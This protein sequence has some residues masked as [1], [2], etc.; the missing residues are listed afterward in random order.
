LSALR[1]ATGRVGS[2]DVHAVVWYGVEYI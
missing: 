2:L 1:V